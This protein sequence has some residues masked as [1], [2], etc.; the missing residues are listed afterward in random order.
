MQKLQEDIY[1]YLG[2]KLKCLKPKNIKH[3]LTHAGV[4]PQMWPRPILDAYHLSFTIA[5][6]FNAIN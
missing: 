2:I 3:N 6:Q 5:L 4:V 1:P